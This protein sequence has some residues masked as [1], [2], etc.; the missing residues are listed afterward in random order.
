M[1]RR[2]VFAGIIFA[3]ALPAFCAETTVNE[4]S[5]KEKKEG[6]KLLF[7]GKSLAGWETY[8]NS[9]APKSGWV[10]EGGS[11]KHIAHGGG[12]DIISA[13]TFG[14]FDFQW[15]WK[16]PASANNGV[17][18][19]VLR[20]HGKTPGPEYQ[21]IDDAVEE[22]GAKRQTASLYDILPP[23]KNKP[24]KPVGEWNHSRILVRGNHVE[25]WLNG[26]KVLEYE[27]GSP[28]LKA[29]IAQS[30]FKDVKKFC[31]KV[32]GHILLTD[33]NDEASFRNVKILELR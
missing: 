32:R 6:W 8:K 28:K 4:L 30:K 16:I 27:I 23:K 3:L 31:E 10:V 15:D 25:H 29:A 14:N 2:F 26:A 7:D 33:H 5:A 1:K 11:L 9:D 22:G 17:K 18:Y 12:G 24:L 20:E 21:M 19:F 13:E